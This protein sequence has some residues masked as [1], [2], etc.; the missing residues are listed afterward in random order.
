MAKEKDYSHIPAGWI[1]PFI[2]D[3]TS[4]LKKVEAAQAVRLGGL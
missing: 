4:V 1:Y 3:E 2:Y